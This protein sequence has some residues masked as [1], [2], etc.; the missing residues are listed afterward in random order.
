MQSI[1]STLCLHKQADKADTRLAGIEAPTVL[2]P[3]EPTLGALQ[4]GTYERA[5][6]APEP[7]DQRFAFVKLQELWAE[8]VVSSD[9]DDYGGDSSD[10]DDP[11]GPGQP[12][13]RVARGRQASHARARKRPCGEEEE[14]SDPAPPPRLNPG[15]SV[16]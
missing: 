10:G 8:E 2:N 11:G 1:P 12:R 5:A 14:D 13:T 3:L 6:P 16:T 4:F 15:S 7:R 9:S